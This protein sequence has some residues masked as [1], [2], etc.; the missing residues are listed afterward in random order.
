MEPV[1]HRLEIRR[2]L[3]PARSVEK[4]DEVL[5]VKAP[6]VTVNLRVPLKAELG[7]LHCNTVVETHSLAS[8]LVCPTL[9]R[10]EISCSEYPAP[11]MVNLVA[12]LEGTLF[13]RV[14]QRIPWSTPPPATKALICAPFAITG[15]MSNPWG[16]I[17]FKIAPVANRRT[18]LPPSATVI[19]K[20]PSSEP[21]TSDVRSAHRQSGS[22]TAMEGMDV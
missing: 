13:H 16:L 17:G 19:L 2:L 10:V 20:H 4:R 7:I 14:L 6:D 9:V 1:G 12:P 18:I 21:G 15:V 8:E 11:N 3:A 22:S 5:P